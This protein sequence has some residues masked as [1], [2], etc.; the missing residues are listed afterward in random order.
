MTAYKSID[1]IVFVFSGYY[2]LNLPRKDGGASIDPGNTWALNPS[3]ALSINDRV[4]LNT[5]IRWSN[6]WPGHMEAKKGSRRQ[7]RETN[8]DLQLGVDFSF[9]DNDILN[10]T[11]SSNVSGSK[12]SNLRLD[13]LHTL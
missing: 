11:F 7:Y 12:G 9:S 6:T 8:T 13:W 3:V 1:P 10:V 4:T 5:G 2:S